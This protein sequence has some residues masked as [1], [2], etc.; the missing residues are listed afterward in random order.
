METTDRQTDRRQTDRPKNGRRTAGMRYGASIHGSTCRCGQV[1]VRRQGINRRTNMH[2][3][4]TVPLPLPSPLPSCFPPFPHLKQLHKHIQLRRS[5]KL[6]RPR[7][8]LQ[9]TAHPVPRRRPP[10]THA[11][12]LRHPRDL[13]LPLAAPLLHHALHFLHAR[14]LILRCRRP[15]PTKFLPAHVPVLLLRVIRPE[16][17]KI[18]GPGGNGDVGQQPRPQMARAVLR[19]CRQAFPHRLPRQREA[20]AQLTDIEGEHSAQQSLRDL[21]RLDRGVKLLQ[22]QDPRLAVRCVHGRLFHS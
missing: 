11:H 10:Y 5:R 20:T 13:F 3:Q 12:S 7:R 18:T 16:G 14:A 1:C 21:A 6:P 19:H 9:P 4:S 2:K 8:H 17:R 15:G 22:L